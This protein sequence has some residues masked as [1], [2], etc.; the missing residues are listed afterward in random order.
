MNY[1]YSFVFKMQF[2]NGGDLITWLF[3]KRNHLELID[4]VFVILRKIR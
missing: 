3:L 4:Q 1:I 2:Q